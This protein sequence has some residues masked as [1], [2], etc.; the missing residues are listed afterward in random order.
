M[1]R[2]RCW[3]SDMLDRRRASFENPPCMSASHAPAPKRGVHRTANRHA[4]PESSAVRA[5]VPAAGASV[6]LPFGDG[7][8]RDMANSKTGPHTPPFQHTMCHPRVWPWATYERQ[9]A[10]RNEASSMRWTRSSCPPSHR[11]ALLWNICRASLVDLEERGAGLRGFRPT[12]ARR[13]TT[14][15]LRTTLPRQTITTRPVPPLLLAPVVGATARSSARELTSPKDAHLGTTG[16]LQHL[17]IGLLFAD[18]QAPLCRR[19]GGS[20][21]TANWRLEGSVQRPSQRFL[22][23]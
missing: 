9:A 17:K 16:A 6:V 10:T 18:A 14:W 20:P 13:A 1:V 8:S 22:E 5:R 11:H 15:T 2:S 23:Q 7:H 12:S 4:A 3:V 21:A 19:V